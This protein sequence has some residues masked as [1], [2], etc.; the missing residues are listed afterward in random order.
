MGDDFDKQVL[1]GIRGTASRSKKLVGDLHNL[2][3]K[4]YAIE[5][6]MRHLG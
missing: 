6:D 5:N 1:K 3:A 2:K 4:I